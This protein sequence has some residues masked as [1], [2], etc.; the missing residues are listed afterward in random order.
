[1][2]IMKLMKKMKKKIQKSPDREES[3]IQAKDKES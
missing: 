1:M 3:D 2:K